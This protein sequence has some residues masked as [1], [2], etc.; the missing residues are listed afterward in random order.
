MKKL[1]AKLPTFL[2]GAVV[3]ITLTAGTAVGAATYLKAT[4]SN[5]KIVVDGSQAK[6]SDSPLNVNGRLYLPVR[7]TANALGYSVES[8]SSSKV[9][10]KEST[11]DG[12][13][14]TTSSSNNASSG[15]NTINPN[16]NT[17]VGKKVKN[18][19][20]TYSTEGKLD[21]DKIR[22][23]LNSGVLGVNDQDSTNGGNTLL[24][25]AIEENNFEAYKAIKR[26]ALDVNVQ[27]DDGKTALMLSVINKNSFYFGEINELKPDYLIK[28]NNGK[29]AY[30]YAEKNSSFQIGLKIYMM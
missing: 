22:T 27:R 17:I 21:A 2:L 19:K 15:N 9:S 12:N 18:L 29:Q 16:T 7:D 23:A 26:N 30:D 11:S 6:L 24:M 8:V 1:A 20:E 14:T 3:G 10:L 13:S 25:Y 5:V 4:Q 28:D